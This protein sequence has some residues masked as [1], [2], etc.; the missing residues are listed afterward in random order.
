MKTS[1]GRSLLPLPSLRLAHIRGD[2]IGDGAIRTEI[3]LL[4]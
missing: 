4:L 1:Q 3:T 2:Y